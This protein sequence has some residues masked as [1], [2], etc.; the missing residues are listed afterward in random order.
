MA[1]PT[2]TAPAVVAKELCEVRSDARPDRE[3]LSAADAG[4]KDAGGSVANKAIANLQGPA[5]KPTSPCHAKWL[6]LGFV[7]RQWEL[8]GVGAIRLHYAA[9]RS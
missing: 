4:A 1:Q 7:E 8:H 9:P 6:P 2:A 3:Q 5:V